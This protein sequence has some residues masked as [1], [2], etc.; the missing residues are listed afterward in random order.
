MFIRSPAL[1]GTRVCDNSIR[2]K[3]L[4]TSQLGV[5]VVHVVYSESV[6]GRKRTCDEN[7]AGMYYY[8]NNRQLVYDLCHVENFTTNKMLEVYFLL[9]F[10]EQ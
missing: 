6:S 5:Q 8:T 7:G 1:V 10:N 3:I 4:H 2:N 9:L